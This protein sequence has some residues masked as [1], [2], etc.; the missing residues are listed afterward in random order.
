MCM[1]RGG[2]VI[3]ESTED[4]RFELDLEIL[5]TEGHLDTILRRYL[6]KRKCYLQSKKELRN[7]LT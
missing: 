5:I 4:T 3:K 2:F 1:G 7:I 6:R